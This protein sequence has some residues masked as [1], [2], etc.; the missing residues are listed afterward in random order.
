MVE[1][2]IEAFLVEVFLGGAYAFYRK[3]G[4]DVE[5][6]MRSIGRRAGSKI[7]FL[8]GEPSKIKK[9]LGQG[10]ARERTIPGAGRFLAE[11]VWPKIFGKK[12]DSFGLSV[13][14]EQR[15]ILSER[16]PLLKDELAF[17]YAGMCERILEGWGFSVVT[18]AYTKEE[19]SVVIVDFI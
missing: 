11:R 10:S 18:R 7:L 9:V 6:K 15:L 12:V 1:G 2:G 4:A 16:N 5:E 3:R 13:K 14:D 19:A 17:F 8:L